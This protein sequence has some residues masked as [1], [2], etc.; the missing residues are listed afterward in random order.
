MKKK[1]VFSL[2]MIILPWLT[3]LFMDKKSF[4]RYLPV[5]SFVNLFISVFSVISNKR[6]WW[7]NKNPFSPGNVDFSYILGP[8]FVAT[9]WIFKLTFGNFPKYLITNVVL[10]TLNAFPMAY[11]WEKV[12]AFKFKKINHIGW[13]FICIILSIIIYGY[14]YLVEKT[15]VNQNKMNSEKNH[16]DQ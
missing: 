9:L 5:A 8:Y 7:V 1:K 6:S 10:N 4:L 15:I 11:A 14:Q 3:I 2:A 16:L 12:G 13:Y